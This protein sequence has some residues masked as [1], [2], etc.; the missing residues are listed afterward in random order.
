MTGQGAWTGAD[1]DRV[2]ELNAKLSSWMRLA[3]TDDD[4]QNVSTGSL[5]G[6]LRSFHRGEGHT[7]LQVLTKALLSSILMLK[8]VHRLTSGHVG[9]LKGTLGLFATERQETMTVRTLP[10]W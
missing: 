9:M 10:A 8:R 1:V 2:L 7:V 6:H 4:V 3:S 5:R